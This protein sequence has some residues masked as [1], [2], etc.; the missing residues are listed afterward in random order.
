MLYAHRL[1]KPEVQLL[2]MNNDAP[3]VL[4]AFTG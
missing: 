4:E 2:L 3:F 1:N